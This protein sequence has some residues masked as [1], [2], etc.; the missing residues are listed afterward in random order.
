MSGSSTSFSCTNRNRPHSSSGS[1]LSRGR[2]NALL[3]RLEQT[4]A[5]CSNLPENPKGPASVGD[6]AATKAQAAPYPPAA[7]RLTIPAQLVASLVRLVAIA[8]AVE[9]S[10]SRSVLPESNGVR[11]RSGLAPARLRL[12]PA[13][14][15][16]PK[17]EWRRRPSGPVFP[18]WV[19][20]RHLDR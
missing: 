10:T 5:S 3:I 17:T 15:V 18:P 13:P 11:P 20:G 16:H 14:A 7:D 9:H 6:G 4:H 2:S 8:A 19:H 1:A 12:V